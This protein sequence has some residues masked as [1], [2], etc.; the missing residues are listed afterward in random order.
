[1]KIICVGRNY[2]DH[3]R[4]LNNPL[5]EEPVIFLKPKSAVVKTGHSVI[6][7]PFTDELHYECE[8]VLKISKNGKNISRHLAHHYFKEWTLGIDFTA[9]DIQQK[10]KSRGLPWELAKSFDN[11]AALGRFIP[12]GSGKAAIFSMHKNGKQVQLGNSAEMLFSFAHIISFVSEYFTLEIGD[13][14]FTGTPAGVGPVT[15][16]DHF[17]GY[18]NESRVLDVHIE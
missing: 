6:Y 13:L 10:L 5:P 8:L 18:L 14:I 15:P 17:E 7:P 1:M 9:R 2:P 16:Y 11:S 4:E 3:A 12:I